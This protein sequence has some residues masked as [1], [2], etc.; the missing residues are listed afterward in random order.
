[1]NYLQDFTPETQEF[2]TEFSFS[3]EQIEDLFERVSIKVITG[4]L[5]IKEAEDQALREM[6]NKEA[7]RML[8]EDSKNG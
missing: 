4:K 7:N 6:F 2:I 3:E 8:E 1:M 5:K